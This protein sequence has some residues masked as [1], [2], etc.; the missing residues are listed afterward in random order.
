VVVGDTTIELP[1]PTYTPPQLP[2]YHFQI[3]PVPSEPPT[4][5][6][7]TEL[8]TTIVDKVEFIDVAET[9]GVLIVSTSVTVLSQP[10]A[11]V[12]T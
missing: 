3:P 7:V 5:L 9:L 1:A 11:F 10:A 2:L 8:P 12:V 4:T 6:R